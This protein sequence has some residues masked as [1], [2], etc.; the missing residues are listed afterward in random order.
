MQGQ[1]HISQCELKFGFLRFFFFVMI[2]LR[3]YTG[4]QLWI[5]IVMRCI[6]VIFIE[7][8]FSLIVMYNFVH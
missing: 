8:Y 7:K 1:Q 3:L 6:C 2:R 4:I 5:N